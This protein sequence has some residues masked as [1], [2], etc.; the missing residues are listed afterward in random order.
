MNVA[1]PAVTV[2]VQDGP[3]GGRYVTVW[4][5]S[6]GALPPVVEMLE[7][8]PED[9]RKQPP[10]GWHRYTLAGKSYHY[11]PLVAPPTLMG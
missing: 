5:T 10:T 9:R 11:R 7:P 6:G 3:C 1:P 4:P 8:I 2:W